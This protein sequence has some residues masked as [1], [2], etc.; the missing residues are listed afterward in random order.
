MSWTFEVAMLK[1]SVLR[2]GL[3]S[4]RFVATRKWQGPEATMS[5]ALW[6]VK[7]EG[8]DTAVK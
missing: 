7:K 1:E 4:T 6:G 3:M 2:V 5:A 8:E